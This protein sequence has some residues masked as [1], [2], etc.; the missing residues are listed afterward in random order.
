[1]LDNEIDLATSWSD[2][3]LDLPQ[4]PYVEPHFD[5]TGNYL[6][7]HISHCDS[8]DNAI[9]RILQCQQ[10]NV[11]QNAQN[12]ETLRPCLG[13]VS[14]E[15]VRKT[16]MVTTQHAREVY[17]VPLRKHFKSISQL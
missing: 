17:N 8:R 15:T 4:S 12:Y 10:H 14:A 16:L 11:T 3:I 2:S 1:V 5:S 9:D 13:W 7:R 6:H